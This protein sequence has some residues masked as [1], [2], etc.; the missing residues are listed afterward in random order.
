MEIVSWVSYSYNEQNVLLIIVFI[1]Q[2]SIA[3]LL[4]LLLQ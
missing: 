4:V 1:F 3:L 2:D